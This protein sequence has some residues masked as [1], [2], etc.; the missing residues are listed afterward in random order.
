MQCFLE[1]SVGNLE[2]S[3]ISLKQETLTVTFIIVVA[4]KPVDPSFPLVHSVSNVICAVVFGHRFSRE[5]ETFHELIKATEYLFKFGG[6]FIYH[7]SE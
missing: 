2:H 6:S 1:S 3:L 4:G 5:D 7:V